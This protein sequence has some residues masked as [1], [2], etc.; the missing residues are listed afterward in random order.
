LGAEAVENGVLAGG[1]YLENHAA[2]I[3]VWVSVMSAP[4]E[5]SPIEVTGGVYRQPR[6]RYF[7]VYAIGLGTEVVKDGVIAGLIQLEDYSTAV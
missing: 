1:V 4:I 2:A 3:I 6:L 7:T 5:D